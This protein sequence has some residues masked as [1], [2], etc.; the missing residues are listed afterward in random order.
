MNRLFF[1]VTFLISTFFGCIDPDDCPERFHIPAEI[2]PYQRYYH[3]GDTI[4]LISKFNR[5]VHEL[6]T[7]EKYDMIN[8][9][10]FPNTL[11]QYLDTMGYNNTILSKYFNLILDKNCLEV[12][13]VSDGNSGLDCNYTFDKDSF[14][15]IYKLIPTRTGNYFLSQKCAIGPNF[16]DQ[17]FPG[18][19][20]GNGYDVIVDMN[21]GRDGNIEILKSS[22]DSLY[23]T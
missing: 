2:I 10:W 23:N 17:N 1:L 12:F 19:C 18:K 13:V 20:R 22:I 14:S 7:D 15:L 21:F 3:I 5:Y 6:H 11:I 4:T 16:N 9:N 8:I